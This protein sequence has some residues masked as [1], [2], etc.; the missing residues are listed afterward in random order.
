M[1]SVPGK[2]V[3]L[4]SNL[5]IGILRTDDGREVRFARSNSQPPE[6]FD[7]LYPGSRVTCVIEARPGT[8]WALTVTREQP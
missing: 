8:L 6:A 7:T 4:R 2:I 3:A 1:N 5:D